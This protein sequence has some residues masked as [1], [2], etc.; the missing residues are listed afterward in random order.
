MNTT[1]TTKENTI[2]TAKE[3]K[4]GIR[5][6][7][8]FQSDW[9]CRP[10]QH[11]KQY[12][13]PGMFKEEGLPKIY[14]HGMHFCQDLIKCFDYYTFDS[15]NHVAE[16]I[17]WGDVITD[18]D[19]ACTNKLE[20]VRELSWEEVL[21]LV[22]VGKYNTGCGNT[23]NFNSGNFNTGKYN[24][25]DCNSGD[26]NYGNGNTGDN[27]SGYG[28]V[29]NFNSGLFNI[30]IY[31][32]G[33]GNTGNFNIGRSNTGDDNS[34]NRNSGDGNIGDYNTGDY[35]K[36]SYN[37]GCFNTEET[38]IRFFNKSS[39]IT[40]QEWINSDAKRLLTQMQY[41]ISHDSNNDIQIDPSTKAQEWWNQLSAINKETIKSIPN[42]NEDIFFDCTGIKVD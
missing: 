18:D 34:G 41:F 5:G 39:D 31:N 24:V 8:V 30:G 37:T 13:C 28:N 42:F 2:I 27:N 22:N 7:K 16:V 10:E 11:I 35:N 9:T 23:G 32:T 26:F 36:S 17:A 33:D 38:T 4:N 6:Y 1:I 20:I 3:N 19:I 15:K 14:L 29:G 12:A 40:Y 25:G 21:R